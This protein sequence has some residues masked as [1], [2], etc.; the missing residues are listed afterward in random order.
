MTNCRTTK[1]IRTVWFTTHQV[2]RIYDRGRPHSLAC[3]RRKHRHVVRTQ[4]TEMDMKTFLSEGRY[5]GCCNIS[6]RAGLLVLSECTYAPELC[7]PKHAHENAYFIFALNGGQEESFG[8][9]NRTYVPGTLAFHPAGEAHCEKLGPKGMRCLHVE[10]RSKWIERHE[11]VSRFLEDGSNFQGGRF[12]WLAQR[13]YQEFCCM[14]D[15]APAAI[16]GLV[17]EILA[18]ASRLRRP[19]S[20]GKRPRWLV[21]AKDLI[22]ARFADS[23]SLSDVAAAVGIHPVSLARAFR[24]QYHCSVGEFIRRVRVESA[25]KAILSLDLPLNEV[26][27]AAGFADQAHFSRTFKRVT[28]LTPGQFRAAQRD[29]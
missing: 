24:S 16:E 4:L 21:Q 12:G 20:P 3:H 14:D 27:L 19:D 13:V 9:R 1:E 22:H 15:V 23:L 10:F 17:L 5:Y 6:K 25:C 11:T 29:C 26:G 2:T 18:E 28:G 7:I 8:N